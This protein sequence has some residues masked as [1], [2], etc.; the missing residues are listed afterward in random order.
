MEWRREECPQVEPLDNFEL[1]T[2]VV[3]LVPRAVMTL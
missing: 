3:M 1:N 2:R